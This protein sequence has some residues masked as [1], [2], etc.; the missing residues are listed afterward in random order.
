VQ[1]ANGFARAFSAPVSRPLITGFGW[2]G[3]YLTQ[4]SLM[5]AAVL[6]PYFEARNPCARSPP[7]N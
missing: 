3:A 7:A 5:A 4:G 2:R 1:S 6:L